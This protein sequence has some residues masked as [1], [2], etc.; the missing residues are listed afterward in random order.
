QYNAVIFQADPSKFIGDKPQEELP[1]HKSAL[2]VPANGDL[3]IKVFLQDAESKDIIMDDIK[4]PS[5]SG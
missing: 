2:A 5:L 4:L 3:K 1:L